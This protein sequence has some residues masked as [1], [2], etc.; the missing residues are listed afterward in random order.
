MHELLIQALDIVLENPEAAHTSISKAAWLLQAEATDPEDPYRVLPTPGTLN[1]WQ[2]R[3]AKQLLGDGLADGCPMEEVARACD[4]PLAHFTRAFQLT[5]G[6]SP[7]R[8][9]RALRIER[10]KAL[11]YSSKLSLAQIAYECG[12]ADQAHFTRA[13]AA[14]TGACPGA[15]RRA[16]RAG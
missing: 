16:R 5:T 10:A 11:L 12:F 13:F 9:Q 2:E 7:L 15:W 8:W 4:L 1:A 6:L 14:A 3:R